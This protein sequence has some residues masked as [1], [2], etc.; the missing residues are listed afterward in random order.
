MTSSLHIEVVNLRKISPMSTVSGSL[1]GFADVMFGS[2]VIVGGFSIIRAAG[3][4]EVVTPPK[5]QSKDGRWFSVVQFS[6]SAVANA[7]NDAI[8]KAFH[9]DEPATATITK[10]E[11][12]NRNYYD[13]HSTVAEAVQLMRKEATVEP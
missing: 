6:D 1:V 2:Q 13:I 9:T 7:V 4:R 8:L 12:E 3:G 10:K 5:K 11:L